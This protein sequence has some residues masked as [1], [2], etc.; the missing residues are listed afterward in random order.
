MANPFDTLGIPLDEKEK[1]QSK[2][3]ERQRDNIDRSF[4]SSLPPL[5]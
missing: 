2:G 3:K 1:E 4:L 5:Y